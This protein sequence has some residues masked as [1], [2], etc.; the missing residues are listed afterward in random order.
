MMF[1]KNYCFEVRPSQARRRL[2]IKLTRL[3][4][5]AVKVFFLAGARSP[6]RLEFYMATLTDDQCDAFFPKSRK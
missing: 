1:M 2:D 6:T 4:D 5:G 3:G